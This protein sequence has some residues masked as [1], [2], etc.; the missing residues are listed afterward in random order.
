[1]KTFKLL[2]FLLVFSMPNV[3]GLVMCRAG[4]PLR[5]TLYRQGE[6]CCIYIDRDGNS[7]NVRE[8][9]GR[10]KPD[11]YVS[12]EVQ[13]QIR[14]MKDNGIRLSHF[15]LGDLEGTYIRLRTIGGEKVTTGYVPHITYVSDSLIVWREFDSWSY[16][17]RNVERVPGAAV[18]ETI[19]YSGEPVVFTIK[20]ADPEKRVIE[21]GTDSSGYVPEG[22][23]VHSDGVCRFPHIV[24]ECDGEPDGISLPF[25]D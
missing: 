13:D 14:K 11:R 1:M 20:E 23:Y 17:I 3:Q 24:W 8:F 21:I 10:V 7:A 16:V 9:I 2:T 5:D 18:V 15:D 6:D 25:E 19:S 4:V 22:L 12:I